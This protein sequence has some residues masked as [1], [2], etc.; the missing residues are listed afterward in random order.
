M[1]MAGWVEEEVRDQG[2]PTCLV[3]GA[4]SEAG[5]AVEILVEQ[6]QVAPG[7]IVLER[8]VRERVAALPNVEIR[9]GCH[10]ERLEATPDKRRVTGVRVAGQVVPAD[11][12]VDS[13]GR[14]CDSSAWLQALGHDAP[15]E[16]RVEI[17][18]AYTTR[19]FRRRPA[20][21]G[22]DLAVIIP[23][24]PSTKR[25]GVMLAQEG[26]RWTVTLITHFGSAAPGELP[27]FIEFARNLPSP[28]IYDV[29][30]EAEPL[31]EAATTRFPAS[32]RRRY[33]RLKHVPEG[34]LVFG[35]AI[36]SFN[37]IYGQGMSVAALEAIE[38]RRALR[39]GHA[40]PGLHFYKL[41]ARVIDTP[42]SIAVG[43][44][45]R[46]PETI[47]QRSAGVKFINW[48]IAKL[49]RAAHHDPA[50]SVAFLRV[51][52]LLAPPPTV[53]RPANVLRVLRGSFQTRRAERPP[54][55]QAQAKA[56]H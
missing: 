44:D 54:D 5:F 26:D 10:A 9:E 38:L 46:M 2:G 15:D 35:D 7:R 42:W 40:N 55:R 24:H 29:L 47:G 31:G 8:A 41:A 14:G 6:Q 21:A 28:D 32:I 19:L 20:H 37:P 50:L 3:H 16:E 48:Y 34:Y 17:G 51:S 13:T 56:A 53:M 27:G 33:E 52:N 36:C 1:A 23:S 25:G 18:L 4:E 49:H 30:R 11:L 12:V 39:S 22:G 43:G 45:L